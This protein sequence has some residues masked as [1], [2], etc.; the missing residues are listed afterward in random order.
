MLHGGDLGCLQVDLSLVRPLVLHTQIAD[1]QRV[2]GIQEAYL[3]L[4]SSVGHHD[5]S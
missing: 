1:V 5:G 4:V 2:A 3:T